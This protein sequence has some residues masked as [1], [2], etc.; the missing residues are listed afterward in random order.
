M[1]ENNAEKLQRF[2]KSVEADI[3]KQAEQMK[4]AA[5]EKYAEA[6]KAAKE[7]ASREAYE[8]I[9]K[10]ENTINARYRRDGA[11]EEQK[12]RK[13]HLLK[14]QQLKE[15]VIENVRK[16]LIDFTDTSDYLSCLSDMLKGEKLT[17][18]VVGLSERDM[19]YAA[20]IK[21]QY[22]VE[23]EKDSSIIL[24]GLSVS[25]KDSNMMIDKTFDSMLDDEASLFSSRFS[26][27]REEAVNG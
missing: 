1:A 21:K 6:I 9:N 5:D 26:F 27:E 4:N 3:S 23:V 2:T 13:E 22:D 18:A 15:S 16:R 11:L 14:R 10:A 8:K 12:L 24:G 19:K 7:N 20:E 17:Y 25:Y